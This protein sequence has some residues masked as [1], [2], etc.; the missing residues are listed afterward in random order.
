MEFSQTYFSVFSHIEAVPSD[1][2][3][4][5]NTVRLIE[6][7]TRARLEKHL[8]PEKVMF[9]PLVVVGP[10][11]AGKGTLISFLTSK[12]PEKFGFSVSYT[13]RAPRQ[14]EVDGVHYNFVTMDKFKDMIANDEFIEHCQVY[15]KMYG[16]AKEQIRKIQNEK[17]IP[18]LDI[19]VQGALKFAKVFPDSNFLA[20]LPPSK[21]QLEK[22]LRG[23]GTDSQE[24]ILHR[25]TFV[26]GEM[27]SL[28]QNK[29]TFNYRI[30][31]EKLEV[32]R[33]TLELLTSALYAEELL[34]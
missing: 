5:R 13:T 17:K 14:G 12:F 6:L 1:L 20:V 15:D 3:T 7:N 26:E 34:G 18:L 25:L 10:S 9:K 8:A 22:R 21:A 28:C 24:N 2:S 11:G 19:D 27:E 16:T 31:N 29:S 23:R 4:V 32:S 30:V 33:R